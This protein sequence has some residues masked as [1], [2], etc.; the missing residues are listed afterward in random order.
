MQ[1][2]QVDEEVGG[3]F[4]GLA[5]LGKLDR[6]GEVGEDAATVNELPQQNLWADSGS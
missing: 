1:R 5:N 4:G 2:K 3:L 6:G